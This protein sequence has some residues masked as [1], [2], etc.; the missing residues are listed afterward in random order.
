[1]IGAAVLDSAVVGNAVWGRP[2]Q[3]VLSGNYSAAILAHNS[4]GS[5]SPGLAQT[6]IIP[7]NAMSLQFS[8]GWGGAIEYVNAPTGL[9]LSFRLDNVE[10][11][12]VKLE[13]SDESADRWGVDLSGHQGFVREIQFVLSADTEVFS[14]GAIIVDDVAFSAQTVP[15]PGCASLILMGGMVLSLLRKNR[16]RSTHVCQSLVSFKKI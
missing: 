6:G 12:L 7:M 3:P 5:S 13:S 2:Q 16:L 1:M 11:P 9:R 10:L 4:Q 8:T 14:E 15:E